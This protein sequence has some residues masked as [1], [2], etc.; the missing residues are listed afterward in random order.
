M[1][2]KR[3]LDAVGHIDD[4]LVAEFVERDM[5]MKPSPTLRR[6][7]RLWWVPIPAV[8][9]CLC[10]AIGLHHLAPLLLRDPFGDRP[11]DLLDPPVSGELLPWSPP[12]LGE[13]IPVV[14]VTAEVTQYPPYVEDY[15]GFVISVTDRWYTLADEDELRHAAPLPTEGYL[16]IYEEVNFFDEETL[17]AFI[18]KWLPTAGDMTGI[19]DTDYEM[20]WSGTS[21]MITPSR[22]VANIGPEEVGQHITFTIQQGGALSFDCPA[23]I[24]TEGDRFPTLLK[25]SSDGEILTALDRGIDYL[26]KTLGKEFRDADIEWR[27]IEYQGS[28]YLSSFHELIVTLN[29]YPPEGSEEYPYSIA[30]L[31]AFTVTLNYEYVNYAHS[32]ELVFKKLTYSEPRN[33]ADYTVTVGKA[34]TIPL[35]EAE[36]H[37]EAGYVYGATGCLLCREVGCDVDF[38]EYDS[39]GLVYKKSTAG[40]FLWSVPF[41]AFYKQVGDE[42]AAVY[43]PAVEVTGL[44]E[45]FAEYT[46]NHTH[47]ATHTN[48]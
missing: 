38:S 36:A 5:E 9:A 42:Y 16:P 47:I 15:F 32:N 48:N 34:K 39:V 6:A 10:V 4:E 3:F 8:A 31:P 27:N 21:G 12:E 14:E 29:G 17:D 18:Q 40:H 24:L 28:G 26:E 43:V 11:T 25:D 2:A 35:A 44:E 41:Y 23:K 20:K 13:D 19:T 46:E 7:K 37:L 33:T 30:S 45:L 1:S 22:Y